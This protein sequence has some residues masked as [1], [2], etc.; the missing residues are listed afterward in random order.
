MRRDRNT[1]FENNPMGYNPMMMNPNM[2][3]P[4]ELP[5]NY[6]SNIPTNTYPSEY[7]NNLES[8]LAKMERGLTRLEGRV[9]KI[10]N[11]TT[12]NV[13]TSAEETDINLNNSMY[14]I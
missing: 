6:Y 8:R 11:T 3:A 14:V 10:E 2:Y 7:S 13:Y 5:N 9:A 12:T 4:N 1:F